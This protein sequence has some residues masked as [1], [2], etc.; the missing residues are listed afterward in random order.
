MNNLSSMKEKEKLFFECIIS[1]FCLLKLISIIFILSICVSNRLY[2]NKIDNKSLLE[3]WNNS[4]LQDTTRLQALENAIWENYLF[5]NPDSGF[6][7]ANLLQSFALDRD[8]DKYVANG[9][10]IK[11]ISYS[12]KDEHMRAL[13]YYDSSLIIRRLIKDSVGVAASLNNIG[14]SYKKIGDYSNAI[15]SY[16]KCLQLQESINNQKG[17]AEV[18]NNIAN[19]YRLKKE[20]KKALDYHELGLEI[21]KR[22]NDKKGIAISL[23]NIGAIFRNQKDYSN[24]K[25]H[26]IESLKICDE[27]NYKTGIAEAL[28]NLGL[29]FEQLDKLDSAQLFYQKGLVTYDEM[30]DKE[31]ICKSL[32]NISGI[33]LLDNGVSVS[34]TKAEEA[35]ALALEINSFEGIKG[36][37]EILHKAYKLEK[38]YYL[39]LKMIELFHSYDSEKHN[40][41]IIR[42]NYKYEYEKKALADSIKAVEERKVKDARLIAEKVENKRQTYF[43]LGGLILALLFGGFIFNRFKVTIRQKGIIIE[44][45]QVIDE[46]LNKLEI[47]NKEI[48]DSINY[49]KRIQSAILP[50]EELMGEYLNQSFILYKPKDI[51][52]GDFYWLESKNNKVLFAVADCT[53]H[54]VPGAMISVV[55]NSALNRAVREFDLSVPGEILTKTRELVIEEFEK[56][57]GEVKDGMDIALC[58]LNGNILKY[59]GA[60]NPLWIVRK[61]AAKVE[62]IKAHKQGIGLVETPKLFPTIETQLNEGDTIYIFSDGYVDQFGGERGKKFMAR[63]FRELLISI[64]DYTMEQQKTMINNAFDSWKGNLEQVDDVCVIGMR[65]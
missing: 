50:T 22:N 61:G 18:L 25:K 16:T 62:E 6:Y 59:S 57:D 33:Y 24:A 43:L 8:N 35:L 1:K 63:R 9:L 34:I 56:S 23:N 21:C 60:N 39:A 30:K 19:L 4:S 2:A 15:I 46:A 55:C 38:K 54:G 3:I 52:A 47:K 45:N 53:G 48:V 14:I 37:T 12:L 64:Q 65:V 36:A 41:E 27:L 20:Y 49:A 31:G 42:Q 29:T 13:A 32:L 5:S 58:S 44:K 11:G 26:I 10:N 7:Y 17:I 40:K 28:N 51:V